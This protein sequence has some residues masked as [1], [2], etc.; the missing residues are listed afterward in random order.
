KERNSVIA[1]SMV[2]FKRSNGQQFHVS[3]T[4]IAQVFKFRNGCIQ[5]AFSRECPQVKFIDD[6]ARKRTRVKCFVVPV[7]CVLIVDARKSMN[8]IWL[9]LRSRIGIKSFIL[10][11]EKTVVCSM[12]C[13]L[14]RGEPPAL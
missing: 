6:G 9:P 14:H 10:V 3:D 1:P 4:K 8:A 7:K 5:G 11:D 13:R 2:T 12:T